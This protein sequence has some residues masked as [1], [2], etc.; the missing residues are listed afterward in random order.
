L[1]LHLCRCEEGVLPDEATSCYEEIASGEEQERPR[2]DMGFF[3]SIQFAHDDVKHGEQGDEV[4][5][6]C[7]DAYL[8]NS[9]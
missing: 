3:L 9:G 7:A 6:L 5:N 8:F 1:I 4:L 2:N